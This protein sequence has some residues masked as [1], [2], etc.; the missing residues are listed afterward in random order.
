MKTGKGG[1]TKAT[2]SFGT[3]RLAFRFGKG[4][5]YKGQESGGGEQQQQSRESC[6]FLCE[7]ALKFSLPSTSVTITATF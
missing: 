1:R 3:T 4:K 2:T 7:L 6:L 5:D